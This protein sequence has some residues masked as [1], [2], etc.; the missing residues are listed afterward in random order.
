MVK[1]S[2]QADGGAAAASGLAIAPVEPSRGAGT[3]LSAALIGEGDGHATADPETPADTPV[4]EP[5]LTGIARLKA[6]QAQLRAERKRVVRELRNAQKRR[7]RLCKRA[8][9]LSDADLVAVLQMR[10]VT[11]SQSAAEGST[12]V[13]G[14]VASDAAVAPA[15]AGAAA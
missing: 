5:L 14:A 12:R 3:G 11:T 1:H 2:W 7:T 13:T 8:R 9:Q 10:E 4:P 15:N 6:T